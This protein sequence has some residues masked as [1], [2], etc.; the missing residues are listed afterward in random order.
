MQAD[1][2]R[3]DRRYGIYVQP[4]NYPTVPRGT[5]RLRITPSPHHS[6]ADIEHLVKALAEILAEVGLAKGCVRLLRVAGKSEGLPS[7]RP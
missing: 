5:E 2:R 7:V 4:I 1:Q 3:A 6:D